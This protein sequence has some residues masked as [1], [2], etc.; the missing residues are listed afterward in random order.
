MQDK[1]KEVA[2]TASVVKVSAAADK[3]TK[4]ENRTPDM[5]QAVRL[6]VHF[7][8][9]ALGA[10]I[11]DEADFG[12]RPDLCSLRMYIRFGCA[13]GKIED[14]ASWKLDAALA[15]SGLGCQPLNHAIHTG[16]LTVCKINVDPLA[17][18][19]LW[20]Y[21]PNNSGYNRDE[22][23]LGCCDRFDWSLEKFW[24]ACK[25]ESPAKL[26]HLIYCAWQR[27]KIR[28][29]DV[30]P[31]APIITTEKTMDPK[32][33]VLKSNQ[34]DMQFVVSWPDS[35][36]VLDN[37]MVM[38]LHNGRD[39]SAKEES[40]IHV[41]TFERV[42]EDVEFRDSAKLPALFQQAVSRQYLKLVPVL[43]RLCV[44]PKGKMYLQD[45]KLTYGPAHMFLCMGCPA[46]NETRWTGLDQ[47]K[48]KLTTFNFS[49]DERT[50][51]RM[52][53]QNYDAYLA[54]AIQNEWLTPA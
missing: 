28:L 47:L 48:A 6:S 8:V 7:Q 29:D 40:K 52:A 5:K 16:C 4:D 20:F 33:Q 12:N 49:A 37:D 45:H 35:G 39:L 53:I 51:I 10:C 9:T 34:V 13:P 30:I 15:S 50:L 42:L 24:M 32:E 19:K 43:P 23:V 54:L 2:V 44:G 21:Y 26:V 36:D 14:G 31:L 41:W 1:N 22:I 27:G 17:N 18:S 11:A 25:N 3:T 46:D 38:F